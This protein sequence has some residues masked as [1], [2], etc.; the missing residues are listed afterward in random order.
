MASSKISSLF[1]T[2]KRFLRSAHLERDFRDPAALEGY[3]VT[4]EVERNLRRLQAGLELKS[5]L[6]FETPPVI[7]VAIG[8][9]L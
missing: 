2:R 7:G 1:K 3:I 6:E 8:P 9:P 5:G 4:P